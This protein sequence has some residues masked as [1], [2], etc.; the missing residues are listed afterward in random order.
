MKRYCILKGGKQTFSSRAWIAFEAVLASS[1]S[2]RRWASSPCNFAYWCWAC[3]T[4]AGLMF[5]YVKVRNINKNRLTVEIHTHFA[6]APAPMWPF[7]AWLPFPANRLQLGGQSLP[8]LYKWLPPDVYLPGGTVYVCELTLIDN[9]PR[10]LYI[11][12]KKGEYERYTWC[13]SLC[14]STRIRLPCMWADMDST[15]SSF[16]FSTAA[17]LAMYVT[18]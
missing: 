13:L 5:S 15:C 14:W 18:T 4:C 6:S 10:P 11:H 12:I 17:S 3:K 2:P 8:H 1:T 7:G 9:T 16:R